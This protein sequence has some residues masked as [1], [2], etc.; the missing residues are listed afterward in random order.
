MLDRKIKPSSIV[1]NLD[2]YVIGQDEPKKVVAVAVYAHYRKI[3]KARRDALELVK[4]NVLLIGPSGTGKTLL[5]ETLSR[6]LGVPFV[7]ADATSL[8]QNRYVN[9]EIEAI[10]QRLVDKADGDLTRAQLGI[11][12]IDEID[13]LKATG[14]QARAVS[15]ESVQ[16]ALL[17][18]MEGSQVKLGGGQYID[19]ASILFICGGAFIG[20]DDI[21]ARTQTYGYI[22]TSKS[23]DRNIIDRLNARVKPTDLFE[24]GLIPEFTGRLPIVARFH[25]LTRGMLVRIL[26]E[27]RNCIYNQ[28]SE[29]FRNEGVELAIEHRVF[30]QIAD[31][32]IEYKAGARSLRG[33]FE[34]LITPIL[35]AVPDDPTIRSVEI[36]SL[37]T[38]PRYI[39]QG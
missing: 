22:S 11:V 6:V 24:F 34:E 38:E 35:Y 7:T 29:I 36:E 18:I 19:T 23:D 15:G 26:I 16:H 9:E 33:I 37:F 32:A 28:Y 39:R 27:P 5:C 21:M 20:L 30:E 13:K 31:I 25:D 12:F 3:E 1:K 4:S 10:L 17:K 8:A 2:E 14:G